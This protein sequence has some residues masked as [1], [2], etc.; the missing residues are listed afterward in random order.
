MRAAT[1]DQTV[2][3]REKWR[4]AEERESRRAISASFI[5]E[6]RL[7]SSSIRDLPRRLRSTLLASPP[8]CFNCRMFWANS[9]QACR[10]SSTCW[11]LAS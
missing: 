3:R 10:V 2:M 4:A 11:S 7:R 6:T 1:S 5:A 9:S 8:V